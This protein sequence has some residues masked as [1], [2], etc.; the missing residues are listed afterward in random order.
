MNGVDRNTMREYLASKEIPAMIYYPV[1]LHMQKTYTDAR[2]KEG[3]FPVTEHLCKNVI[4]LP[5]HTELNDEQLNYITQH[6]L[7]FCK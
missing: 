3:V 5:I 4:S 6:V 1:P 7:E 2:Y